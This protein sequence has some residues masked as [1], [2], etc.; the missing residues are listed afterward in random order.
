MSLEAGETVKM[1]GD[2]RISITALMQ[3]WAMG[4]GY[5]EELEWWTI[6]NMLR[7]RKRAERGRL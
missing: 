4:K 2:R 7:E 1:M 3:G 6:W 5:E